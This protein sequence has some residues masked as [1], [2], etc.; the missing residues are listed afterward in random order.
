[1]IK[2]LMSKRKEIWII[3]PYASEYSL[4]KVN[5]ELATALANIDHEYNVKLWADLNFADK[6]PTKADFE[7]YPELKKLATNEKKK[8]DIA[9]INAF[10]KSFP[11]NFSLS[12]IDAEVKIGYLAWEESGFPANIVQEFNDELHLLMVTSE[13]VGRVMRNAGISIPIVNVSEGIN[14]NILKSE[15]FSV[16]TKK[17]FKFLHVS[18]GLPRKGVDVL[19]KAYFRE[20]T[21]KD[22]ICLIIKTYHN[23]E[24]L[25]PKL[26]E[27]LKTK[28]SPEVEVIYDLSLTEGQ[29]AYLYEKADAVV[30]PSRAEGFG[31]PVAE[32][33]LKKVPVI[34][35]GYS[36]Q[37]DFVSEESAWLIDYEIVKA[38]SQLELRDSYWA[39]PDS[40]HLQ[41][42]MR[43]IH[44]QND[45]ALIKQKVAQAYKQAIKITWE[46]TA[47][48]VL[49]NVRF[50]ESV[51]PLKSKKLAIIS[52]YNSK[53]GIAEYSRDLYPLITGAFQD[54]MIFANSDAEI[55][56]KDDENIM[57][58]WEY[59]E[60]DFEATLREVGKFGTDM[61]HIQYNPP[62]YNFEALARL[63]V[64]L[65]KLGIDVFVTIHSIPEIN[66]KSLS[67]RF[68]MARKILVHSEEDFARLKHEGVDNAQVFKHGIR[69]FPIE[70]VVRLRKRVGLE[71]SLVVATHGLI[72]ERKGLL[73]MLDAV[74]ILKKE[75]SDLLY[76]ALNAV[77]TDNAS[78]KSVY[79]DMLD[80]V[81]KL[82]LNENVAI[83]SD[84]I[85][86]EEIVK[87]LQLADVVVLPYAELNEG[88]SGA[89][90]YAMASGRPVI[91]T[92]SQIFKDF[93]DNVFRITD[94]K[95]Q[96]IADGILAVFESPDIYQK[97]VS[98]GAKFIK[99]NSW[100]RWSTALLNYFAK[101]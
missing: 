96:T 83:I 4:A 60:K 34:T 37:M 14:Q 95:P 35:T 64:K 68:N 15:K 77:N 18:S 20:F 53:C 91:T 93:G 24:N 32:A 98:R 30:I 100:E 47:N 12:S 40:N 50:A 87:V 62:F 27:Q 84:F 99:A 85:E 11:R 46:D 23:D 51:A 61:V 29:I 36:G 92:N 79:A 66:L 45:E 82:G 97:Y 31:L 42:L 26:L 10:P 33:M 80:K 63:I 58:V 25:I 94:N 17:R 65:T 54:Y 21:N 7:R 16:K 28:D 2:K 69:E 41:R 48:K 52:T 86:K 88:A 101:I 81:E 74:N 75:Y 13:H 78:S 76:I 57:R 90:R 73:E 56:F 19:L 67:S 44:K 5:R 89:V 3:G 43:E 9:I 1:M 59:S 71:N 38:Q 39:E 49:E 22:D 8:T 55:V 6:L 70:D 72:H